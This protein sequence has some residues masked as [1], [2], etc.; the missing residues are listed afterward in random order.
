MRVIAGSARGRPLKAPPGRAARPTSDRVREAMFSSLAGDVPGA[1]VLDLFAGT[2][3]LGI[4]ALSRGAAAAT[5]V[6][7][8]A[9]TIAVLRD[10]VD[11]ADVG[12]RATIVRGDAGTFVRATAAEPFSV[13]LCDPPYDEP[14][15]DV[16]DLLT[17]L[18]AAGGLASDAVV[19]VERERRDPAL[20]D[21]PAL[22]PQLGPLAVDRQRSYGDTVLL[23]LRATDDEKDE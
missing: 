18:A 21:L 7:R 23:Y 1:V 17:E 11:R 22:R 12:D 9:S 14:L 16:L 19:V 20:H 6:E 3:A 5:F 8:D 13:V 2:G 15:V 4:E 10:N